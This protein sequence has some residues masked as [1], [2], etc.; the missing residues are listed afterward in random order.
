MAT[1]NLY[2]IYRSH[3]FQLAETLV[4]KSSMMARAVNLGLYDQGLSIPTDQTQ[5]KY[6]LHLNGTYHS[7]DKTMYVISIDTMDEIAFTKDNLVIH[8]ATRNA[9]SFGTEYY[10]ELVEKYPQQISLILG[11]LN[12][13]DLTTAIDAEDG[14]ILYHDLTLIETNEYNVIPLLEDWIKKTMSRWMNIGY[15]PVN[16]GTFYTAT[17]PYYAPAYW[18]LLF[19]SIPDVV[20]NIR[21][22]NCKTRYAHSFHIRQYLA[23]NGKLDIFM[24][25]LNKKQSLFLYRNLKY[26]HKHAGKQKTFNLLLEN[27]LT[28]AGIPL[29]AHELT[30]NLEFMP[31]DLTPGVDLISTPLNMRNVFPNTSVVSLEALMYKENN[32]APGNYGVYENAVAITKTGFKNNR[33]NKIPTKVLESAVVD[34]T[35]SGPFTLTETL[36]NH[37][38]YFSQTNRYTAFIPFSHPVTGDSFSLNAKD[39]FCLFI[40]ALN[41]SYSN[42]MEYIPSVEAINVRKISYATFAELRALSTSKYID[43]SYINDT[44]ADLLPIGQYISVESFHEACVDIQRR[45]VIHRR[46]WANFEHKDSRGQAEAICMHLYPTYRYSLATEQYYD[47]WLGSRSMDFSDLTEYDFE[48]LAGELLRSAT[49]FNVTTSGGL[50]DIQR[51]LLKLM[52]RLTSYNVQYVSTIN[53]SPYKPVPWQPV[54]IGDV[55]KYINDSKFVY[56]SNPRVISA[57]FKFKHRI[58]LRKPEETIRYSAKLLQTEELTLNMDVS[59][60]GKIQYRIQ[61]PVTP[62]SIHSLTSSMFDLSSI[63]PESLLPG[64]EY[65]Q[66]RLPWDFEWMFDKE[67]RL[68]TLN[69]IIERPWD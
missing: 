12:P 25:A 63:F 6:Y 28:E 44:L 64:F 24:D 3:V 60:Q 35:G 61:S 51:T 34:F 42:E 38:L 40:Y 45:M 20:F 17:D 58:Q 9:Y 30:H 29:A 59:I 13:I 33:I 50:K 69:T 62:I 56:I 37:W 54:R 2:Q 11:I 4:V 36:I 1:N 14:S 16:Q 66:F 68:P 18:A 65:E 22:D 19:N 39:A 21:L 15:G 48:I 7:T 46:T 27:I 47:D 49:G 53:T 41:K 5:W 32:N 10:K 55:D 26:I 57:N 67:D 31:S 52:E 43:D 8:R 23:S